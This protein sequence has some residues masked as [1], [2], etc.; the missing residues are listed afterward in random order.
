MKMEDIFEELGRGK[1]PGKKYE[2]LSIGGEDDDDID[3]NCPPLKYVM[4]N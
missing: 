2:V 3:I 1:F 4:E